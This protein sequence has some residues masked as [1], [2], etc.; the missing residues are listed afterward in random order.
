MIGGEHLY[1][2]QS[3]V[4]GAVK[5]GRS[6]DPSERLKQLQTASPHKLRVI[7]VLPDQGNQETYLHRRLARGRTQGGEEWFHHDAL[8][9]LPDDI[10]ELLDLDVL[11]WWWNDGPPAKAQVSPA[12]P[13]P[14]TRQRKRKKKKEWDY[15]PLMD[16]GL[17]N[18]D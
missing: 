5:V 8:A 14:K 2:I 1:L 12:Q 4:T 16:A 15:N 18:E 17:L 10:Y 13:S 11:D 3:D 7:L 9:E 6:Q